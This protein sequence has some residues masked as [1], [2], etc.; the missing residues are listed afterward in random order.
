M[1]EVQRAQILL[2]YADQIP[3]WQI[4]KMVH[5]S[6]PTIYKCIDKALADGAEAGLQDYYHRPF[7]P[8]IDSAAK[9]WVINLACSKPKDQGLAAELWTYSQ[10]AKYTRQ[11]APLAGHPSLSKAAK[12]QR[13]RGYCQPVTYSRIRSNIIWSGE[14]RSS[15]RKGS[16]F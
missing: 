15:N 4:Q 12:R 10:R 8:I 9:T 11:N 3:L 7:K 2:H 14:T 1:R 16:K 5:L 6:R 13:S